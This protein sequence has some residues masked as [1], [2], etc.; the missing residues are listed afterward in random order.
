MNSLDNNDDDAII[1]E[2]DGVAINYCYS[3]DANNEQTHHMQVLNDL[4]ET[5]KWHAI[6]FALHLTIS[7]LS[8][9]KLF[10]Y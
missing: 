8:S 1:D 10:Y 6:R 2:N 5:N 9:A 4:T 7:I 3:N